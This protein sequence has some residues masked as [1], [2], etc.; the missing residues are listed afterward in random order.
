MNTNGTVNLGEIQSKCLTNLIFHVYIATWKKLKSEIPF[1]YIHENSPGGTGE[2]R[3]NKEILEEKEELLGFSTSP[4]Q[5]IF[6]WW[7]HQRRAPGKINQ[8][9]GQIFRKFL[10]H[11]NKF[12][13]PGLCF[14]RENYFIDEKCT[15]LLNGEKYKF[16]PFEFKRLRLGSL[17]PLPTHPC[18]AG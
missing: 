10:S 12:T 6:N 1:S 2:L 14:G 16:S 4:V 11:L 18:P 9:I 3:L 8:K 7:K 15:I 5:V 17:P 13:S